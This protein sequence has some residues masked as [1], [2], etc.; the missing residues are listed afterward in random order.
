MLAELWRHRFAML[1][2]MWR[3][4]RGANR[5]EHVVLIPAQMGRTLG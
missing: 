2:Q 4:R 3:R 1:T 5:A